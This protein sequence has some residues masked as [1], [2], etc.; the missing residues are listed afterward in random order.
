MEII[1]IEKVPDELKRDFKSQCVLA[2]MTMRET[3][4]RLMGMVVEDRILV[5]PVDS[6]PKGKKRK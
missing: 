4:I 1:R 2:G 6:K 3:L 5:C